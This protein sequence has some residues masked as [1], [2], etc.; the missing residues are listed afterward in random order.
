MV[1]KKLK[2]PKCERKFSMP[3]HLARHV[4]SIHGKKKRKKGKGV[5]KKRAKKTAK[6][7]PPKG[8]RRV[9]RPKGVA[10]KKVG[11]PKGSG[12]VRGKASG[13]G[14]AQ[15]LLKMRECYHEL[16]AKR[17]ALDSQLKALARA[18]KT[19]RRA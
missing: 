1:E 16:L 12:T 10:K 6:K 3:A 14:V 13:P 9:G 15:L 7:K 8:K 4:S 19:L 2:C 17:R 11:R 18:M 5:A